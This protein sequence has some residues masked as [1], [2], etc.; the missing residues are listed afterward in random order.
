M[1]VGLRYSL[2]SNLRFNNK[3][4]RVTGSRHTII[5]TKLAG[6]RLLPASMELTFS[7]ESRRRSFSHTLSRRPSDTTMDNL[8]KPSDSAHDA[9]APLCQS[10]PTST[11]IDHKPQ[12]K[13]CLIINQEAEIEKFTQAVSGAKPTI[14]LPLLL[15]AA[16]L[17]DL[18]L[19]LLEE[20][21]LEDAQVLLHGGVAVLHV[22][23]PL[24]LVRALPA[25]NQEMVKVQGFRRA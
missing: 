22:L 10:S 12:T 15:V 13:N 7:L 17:E 16:A 23:Q 8:W 9:T 4:E 24:G 14:I 11:Q 1:Y 5:S 6:M 19:D 18:P 2:F 25:P 3:T 20:Q 21:R